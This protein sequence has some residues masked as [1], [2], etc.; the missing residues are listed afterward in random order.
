[1]PPSSA[2]WTCVCST[3][4]RGPVPPGYSDG[5]AEGTTRDHP[6]LRRGASSTSNTSS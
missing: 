6:E 3:G 4:V 5:S 2:R 1:V